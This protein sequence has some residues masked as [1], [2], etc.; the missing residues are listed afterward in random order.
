MADEVKII[1]RRF[2][3]GFIRGYIIKQSLGL[4]T[5]EV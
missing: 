3:E 5:V 2:E 4:Y 1:E